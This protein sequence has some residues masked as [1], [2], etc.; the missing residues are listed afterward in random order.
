MK[1]RR[2]RL[3]TILLVV[4]VVVL[5]L[6]LGGIAV[7]RIYESALIRQTETELIAQ[8][9]FVAAGYRATL[10][11]LNPNY[12]AS[13]DYGHPIGERWLFDDAEHWRPRPAVLDLAV[14]RIRPPAPEPMVAGA[15]DAIAAAVGAELAPVLQ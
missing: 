9:A 1:L 2:L 12:Y 14:D 7:L 5:A 15:P 11:N 4:N 3:R 6:P 13:D 8:G 10:R